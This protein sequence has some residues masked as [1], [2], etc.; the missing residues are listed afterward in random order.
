MNELTV[1][2]PDRTTWWRRFGANVID[3]ALAWILSSIAG[4]FWWPLQLLVWCAF[5]AWNNIYELGLEGDSIGRRIMRYQILDEISYEPIGLNRATARFFGSVIDIA[6]LGLGY[7]IPLVN[8][9]RLR[10]ADMLARSAPFDEES[11]DGQSRRQLTIASVVC[12]AAVLMFFWYNDPS[13]SNRLSQAASQQLVTN[14]AQNATNVV[15]AYVETPAEHSLPTGLKVTDVAV[16]QVWAK[17]AAANEAISSD[18]SIKLISEGLQNHVL[19]KSTDGVSLPIGISDVARIEVSTNGAK[20][21]VTLVPG[22]DNAGLLKNEFA[23][24]S[25]S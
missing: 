21:C 10:I 3:I 12:C 7:L 22:R 15:T 23:S 25:C 17:D 19:W 14:A 8:K 18:V 13:S 5:V 4:F 9:D 16:W 24:G 20:V 11:L 1:M 6:F 2:A